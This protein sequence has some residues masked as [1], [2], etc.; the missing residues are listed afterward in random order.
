MSATLRV[1]DFA[2]NKTLFSSPPPIINIATRQHPVTI[3]FSRRTHSDYV[4]QAIEKTVKIHTQ[5][6]PGGILIFLTGQNEIV[7]VCRRLEARF[8]QKVIEGRQ[9][10]IGRQH[11]AVAN[12]TSLPGFETV[13]LT[14]CWCSKSPLA[15]VCIHFLVLAPL[16]VED[17]EL[18]HSSK[19]DGVI[20]DVDD[21]T[22][23][24]NEIL[25]IDDD[26][27]IDQDLGL[28]DF[29]NRT[30]DMKHSVRF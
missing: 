3:H 17:V 24:D 6:P 28:E 7:G 1:T 29:S 5:L 30:W 14:Q 9:R 18:D 20:V 16:E 12:K 13:A 25:E 2:E 8:G 19:D 4:T 27:Q 26:G 10:R 15:S 11:S 21:D 23:E 22:G